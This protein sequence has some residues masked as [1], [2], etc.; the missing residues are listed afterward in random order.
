MV[1][2]LAIFSLS[3]F[4]LR[5]MPLMMRVITWIAARTRSVGL[6]MAARHLARTPPPTPCR[7][8]C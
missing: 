5:L 4:F 8:C 6:M 7:W 1:P 2:A 3:L